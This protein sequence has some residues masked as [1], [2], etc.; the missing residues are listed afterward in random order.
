LHACEVA[1]LTPAVEHAPSDTSMPL[2]MQK[3]GRVWMPGPHALEQPLHAP[4]TH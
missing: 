4:E 3:T 1:G 2:S